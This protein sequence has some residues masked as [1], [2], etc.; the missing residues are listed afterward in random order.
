MPTIQRTASD[1]SLNSQE[2]KLPAIQYSLNM[3]RQQAPKNSNNNSLSCDNSLS[4][5][6]GDF[7]MD[8]FDS[9]SVASTLDNSLHQGMDTRDTV[10]NVNVP[11]GV[12]SMPIAVAPSAMT[13]L[14]M[15]AIDMNAIDMNVIDMNVID[16]NAIMTLAYR[17][18]KNDPAAPEDKREPVYNSNTDIISGRGESVKKNPVN[19]AFRHYLSK[20]KKRHISFTMKKDKVLFSSAMVVD[21]IHNYQYRFV[22]KEE[23]NSDV[24]TFLPQE[25]AK[26][27]IVQVIRDTKKKGKKNKAIK[28]A[29]SFK[30]KPPNA[31]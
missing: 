22:N 20:C 28:D 4:P 11:Q 27:K 26:N 23:K 13:T 1:H 31:S 29:N 18:K 5:S 30:K 14:D 2:R 21:L 12:A 7:L 3:T 8:A 25:I 24:I 19:I 10:S 17:Y 16:M 6:V 9:N 15:N